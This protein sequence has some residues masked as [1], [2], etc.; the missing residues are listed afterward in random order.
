MSGAT[1]FERLA[2][3]QI[4]GDLGT[5]PDGRHTDL[6][7]ITALGFAPTLGSLLIRIKGGNDHRSYHDAVDLISWR[8]EQVAKRKKWGHPARMKRC[9]VEALSFYILDMCKT[10]EGRGVLAHSYSGPADQDAGATCSSC[11]GTAKA[12]RTSPQRATAILRAGE[13]PRLIQEII[14]AADGIVERSARLA[15]GISRGKLYGD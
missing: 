3:S 10:C 1:L 5:S 9:A 8:L 13:T 14:D 11:G 4:S 2:L 15:T 6:D 12:S 7:R